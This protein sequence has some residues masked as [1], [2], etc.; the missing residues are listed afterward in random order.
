MLV[1]E[2]ALVRKRQLLFRPNSDEADQQVRLAQEPIFTAQANRSAAQMNVDKTRPLVQQEILSRYQLDAYHFTLQARRAA[3]PKPSRRCSMP[4]KPRAKSASPKGRGRNCYSCCQK[5]SGP[6]WSGCTD[7]AK[8]SA[9][10]SSWWPE[11]SYGRL[12]GL[13]RRL[14]RADARGIWER[15]L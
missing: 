5:A 4:R 2:V 7:W 13:A 1:D 8:P 3:L 6:R 15:R 12:P 10:A 9:I 11:K 14:T